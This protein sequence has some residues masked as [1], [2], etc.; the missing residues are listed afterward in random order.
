MS[1]EWKTLSQLMV[2]RKMLR[3]D[4]NSCKLT[5][6]LQPSVALSRESPCDFPVHPVLQQTVLGASCTR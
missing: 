4:K 5:V 1:L 6:S 2:A 3:H